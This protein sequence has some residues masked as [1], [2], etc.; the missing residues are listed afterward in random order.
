MEHL[1]WL[2]LA[3]S[4]FLSGSVMFCA[5]I[6]KIFLHTDV[7]EISDD[8]T[9]GVFNVFKHCGAKA[10]IP[11]LILELSKGAVPVLLASLSQNTNTLA[12]SFVMAAPVLGHAVGIFNRLRGGKCVAVTFGVTLGLIPVAWIAVAV[13]VFFYVLFS[14][15]FKI[16]SRTVRSIVVY[17]LFAITACTVFCLM[18]LI[19]VAIGCLLISV[20]PIVKFSFALSAE[21]R[22]Q[23]NTTS[24]TH[25]R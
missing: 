24:T 3:V 11:C 8:H 25:N 1:R 21:R 7:Y 14:T 18:R 12:F 23:K 13:L 6:P 15:L 16:E 20:F 17:A 19:Y 5:I 22:I 10:G 4:G 9:Y 2:L